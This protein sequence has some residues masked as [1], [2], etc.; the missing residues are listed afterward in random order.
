MSARIFTLL[1]LGPSGAAAA[2]LARRLGGSGPAMRLCAAGWCDQQLPFDHAAPPDAI[3]LDL[4]GACQET[5]LAAA[6]PLLCPAGAPVV[7]VLDAAA[8]LEEALLEAGVH[9]CLAAA[10]LSAEGLRR[11]ALRAQA[12][13]HGA[14]ACGLGAESRF[15]LAALSLDDGLWDWDVRRDRIVFSAHWKAMLGCGDA[16]IGERSSAWFDRIH[17]DDR[18]RVSAHLATFLHHPLDSFAEEYRILHADG[19][20]RWARCRAVA[21]RNA[22]GVAERVAGSQSDITRW[23]LAEEQLAFQSLHDPLTGLPNRVLFIESL[24]GAL[25]RVRRHPDHPFAVLC[26][27]LDRFKHINDS[28]GH[29]AGDALLRDTARRLA[30]NV[31]PGDVV[32][33]LGGDEFALLIEGVAD[34]LDACAVADRLL[35]TLAKAYP[36]P[37]GE[38]IMS[39]SIGIA[40]AGPSY[41]QPEELLR[42]ADTAMYWAKARGRAG[43]ALFDTTMHTHA[44]E[45]LRL[46]MD[47]RLAIE[48]EE[49][50]VHYQPIVALD[51]GELRGFEALVRW[52][53]PQRGMVAPGAFLPLA[54]ETGLIVAIDRIVL[55]AACRQ[56]RAWEAAAPAARG[57]EMHVNISG[58]EIAQPALVA[59]VADVLA[60]TGLNPGQ[61]QLEITEGVLIEQPDAVAAAIDSLRVMGVGVA[62]DDFGTGY[63][64]LSYLHRFPF[65]KL[66]IDRSFVSQLR[67]RSRQWAIVQAVVDLGHTLRMRVVAEGIETDEQLQL[68]REM[69]CDEAQGWRF[70]RPLSAAD[71]LALLRAD[72]PP[73]RD[74]GPG[75]TS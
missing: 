19:S 61:L 51:S 5:A 18:G 27:D 53:H 24:R 23:K 26:L 6:A 25:G 46:E 58:S 70:A 68:L 69:G 9:E 12:R 62:L 43:Y 60:D 50:V 7:G 17:P 59:Y 31:R 55:G 38:I 15:A 14:R 40:L 63:S 13:L 10:E 1:L 56:L 71:T 48:R 32:A 30:T 42:D 49:L 74:A 72:V 47:L 11:A 37:G 8:G 73:W 2:A 75:A 29:P 57:L 44:T 41:E 64:S 16:D 20:Y 35:Q 66:K 22:A 34:V 28:L 21:V 4:R 67:P 65:E 33:R 39:A 36:V 3:V 54:E 45:R 52:V